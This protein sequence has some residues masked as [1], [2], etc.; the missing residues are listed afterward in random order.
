MHIFKKVSPLHSLLI[1]FIIAISYGLV[2]KFHNIEIV[3]EYFEDSA[4]D[5][6]L[7]PSILPI[8]GMTYLPQEVDNVP[9]IL[10]LAIDYDYLKKEGL[11]DD[12]NESTYG[13]IFPRSQLVKLLK[14]I[15][16]VHDKLN[17]KAIFLDYDLSYPQYSSHG[18]FSEEDKKFLSQLSE[19]KTYKILLPVTGE[20]KF[21]I[22]KLGNFP[23]IIPVSVDLSLS[24]DGISRRYIASKHEYPSA[25]LYLYALT[26]QYP[27]VQK[28]SEIKIGEKKFQN[29][30][31][32]GNRIIFKHTTFSNGYYES[33]W[34]NLMLASA[35]MLK[36]I[37]FSDN[38]TK[39]GTYVLIGAAYTHSNDIVKTIDDDFYGVEVH[40]NSLMSHFHFDGP[41]KTVPI[42]YALL[43]VFCLSFLINYV[44]DYFNN[45]S[46]TPSKEFL[47]SFAAVITMTI[48]MY[49]LSYYLLYFQKMWFNW[50]IPLTL[51]AIS[52]LVDMILKISTR[53]R[54]FKEKRK[55]NEINSL[56]ICSHD[57]ICFR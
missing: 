45:V 46:P 1:S 2:Y 54:Y 42:G 3:R 30:D 39:N 7:K 35:G 13:Y 19:P 15:D 53:Y 26:Y 56:N 8:V 55:K 4:F 28:K 25:S 41:L 34:K 52:E 57:D 38:D 43:A 32:I 31:V 16:N 44:F 24:S 37:E 20:H 18:E 22:D 6:V 51:F 5:N 36:N 17:I 29:E 21:Y 27:I 11:I 49:G 10:V 47:F 9:N 23:W 12:H 14:S 48:I 33:E 40:A 50:N